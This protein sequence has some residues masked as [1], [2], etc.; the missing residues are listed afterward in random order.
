MMSIEKILDEVYQENEEENVN[1]LT[2]RQ[3]CNIV[4]K[5][6]LYPIA[7]DDTFRTAL[8]YS[9]KLRSLVLFNTSHI[10]QYNPQYNFYNTIEYVIDTVL[11]AMGVINDDINIVL[12]QYEDFVIKQI[13]SNSQEIINEIKLKINGISRVRVN[14]CPSY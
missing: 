2:K 6:L 1:P 10:G 5:L 7:D 8:Y 13:K 3:V 12:P 4:N 9:V 14:D 11:K